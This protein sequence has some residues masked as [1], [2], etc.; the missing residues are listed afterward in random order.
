MKAKLLV[1]SN[2]VAMATQRLLRKR[3][4]ISMV[5]TFMMTYRT[6]L[7][8]YASQNTILWT[9]CDFL[10]YFFPQALRPLTI[11]FNNTAPVEHFAKTDQKLEAQVTS[12]DLWGKSL[13][14]YSP[15][16]GGHFEFIFKCCLTLSEF[17]TFVFAYMFAVTKKRQPRNHFENT[18]KRLS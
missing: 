6:W 5:L 7:A 1:A 9:D 15:Q 14:P 12:G 16:Q 13:E 10:I 17:F 8:H 2:T 4:L 11:F 18:Y 3:T